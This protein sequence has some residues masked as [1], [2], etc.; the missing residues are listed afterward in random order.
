VIVRALVIAALVAGCWLAWMLGGML[1]DWAGVGE[2]GTIGEV[3][4]VFSFLSA[5]EAATRR[6]RG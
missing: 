5:A 3:A 6:L 1:L 2:L 4:T